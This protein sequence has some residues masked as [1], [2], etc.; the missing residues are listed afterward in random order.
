MINTK[1]KELT[2]RIAITHVNAHQRGNS[3]ESVGNKIVDEEVKRAANE[4][5][6]NVLIPIV[7]TLE[8]IPVFSETEEKK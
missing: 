3:F 2:K 4:E 7:E 5:S 1:G 8:E 6:I